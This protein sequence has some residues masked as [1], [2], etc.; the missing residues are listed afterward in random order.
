MQFEESVEYD[1]LSNE[2]GMGLLDIYTLENKIYHSA[3]SQLYLL[4]NKA[5]HEPFILKAVA[6]RDIGFDLDALKTIN[7]PNIVRVLDVYSTE[8]YTYFLKEYILG[9][10][11]ERHIDE[12][13]PFHEKDALHIAVE[14]C[15]ILHYLH[16]LKPYPIIYRDLKPANIMITESRQ[17]KLIDM[18]SVRQY[19]PASSKDTL[20]IGTEGFAAPEQFGF[21]QTDIRTD[22]YT[23][24]TT[25]Y[26]L[27]SGQYPSSDKFMLK[28]IQVIQ[29]GLSKKT[30]D[31]I[32]KSTMFNPED[33]YQN[34]HAL[35]FELSSNEAQI[36]SRFIKSVSGL[37][38][39]MY[40]R[41]AVTFF[42]TLTAY[43]FLLSMS[44]PNHDNQR[45][46]PV[47]DPITSSVAVNA[48]D[49]PGVLTSITKVDPTDP[50]IQSD[51]SM[52]YRP[53]EELVNRSDMRGR[54][55]IH[56]PDPDAGVPSDKTVLTL[57][58]PEESETQEYSFD[59]QNW[60]S[61]IEP[62]IITQSC[63]V[64]TR[65]YMPDKAYITDGIDLSNVG[66]VVTRRYI[67]HSPDPEMEVP[68]KQ[69]TLTIIYPDESITQEYS[70]DNQ[71]WHPYIEPL[72]ITRNCYVN[73]RAFMPDEVYV[74][75]GIEFSN[76]GS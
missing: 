60:Q 49:P 35:K 46:L 28:N 64:Y 6:H 67:N 63:Y 38:R 9:I 54:Y 68:S 74:I 72:I 18:D 73:T 37:S 23:L 61:Y 65:A 50:L 2:Y 15:D 36:L 26:Y 71:N 47:D 62:L 4:R 34:I 7:H 43:L 3:N 14:L 17:I 58:Y 39:K 70:F 42:I 40:V 24:G 51:Y 48:D 69:K 66:P 44:S 75:G 56:S 52:L 16:T 22:I 32:K 5:T 8:K 76:V 1:L 11:L 13:G 12:Y 41:V 59:N 19:K 27:L 20:Y 53:M 31:C 30:C 21:S 55:I 57:L 10:T 45:L 33:R 25:L 29:S